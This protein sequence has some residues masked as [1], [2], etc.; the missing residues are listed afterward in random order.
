MQGIYRITNIVNGKCYIGKS[1]NIDERWYNHV[2]EL[3]HNTHPN[4]H[5][6]N[7]WNLYGKECF[8]FD[9]ICECSL[10]EIND[11]EKKYIKSY[12]ACNSKYGYNIAG[13]G[14][15]GGMSPETRTKISIARRGMN[16]CLSE[17][18]A[19]R[20]K[21]LLYCGID[22]KEIVKR[23][24]ISPK[25]I[26]C[27]VMGTSFGYVLP[28][29]NDEIHYARK[30]YFEERDRE[31]LSMYDSGKTITEIAN[32]KYT[33]SI[34]EK[35][36]YA[37]RKVEEKYNLRKLDKSQELELYNDYLRGL[38]IKDLSNKYD[39]SDTTVNHLIR[40]LK[41]GLM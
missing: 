14:E 7:A 26:T 13:G 35:C 33:Q 11:L 40:K 24:H 27:I 32:E 23:Y 38:S 17:K 34:V 6:Q 2:Y 28:E 21:M 10:D 39:I 22:R 15:G 8:K 16:S 31:I 4:I 9:I 18:D 12:D 29:I 20:I 25:V 1:K 37:N 3:N 5:L 19:R 36:I 30:R 41:K